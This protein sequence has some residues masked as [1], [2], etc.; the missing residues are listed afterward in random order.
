MN[1]SQREFLQRYA[2]LW[3]SFAATLA[4]LDRRKPVGA[5][6][7]A[8]YRQVCQHL[9]LAR[10]RGYS[11]QIV[12][13]LHHLVL[14]GHQHLYGTRR[15][16]RSAIVHF[17]AAGF[18]AAVRAEWRLVLIASALLVLPALAMGL[19]THLAPEMAYAMMDPA[20][21]REYEEMYRPD[22]AHFGREH[23]RDA[24]SD[25][26]MFGYYIWNNIQVAFQ[27][28]AT[29]IALG[30]G[31]IVFLVYNGLLMGA[32]AAHLQNA[33]YTQMFYSFVIGHGAFELTAIVFAG[34]A[35][36]RIG[37]ALL[38]PGRH[39]RAH[40]LRLAG[41]RT[42]PIVYG[43]AC[44]LVI[45][46]LLEAFWSSSTLIPTPAKFAM[47]TV[48]WAIVLTYFCTRGRTRSR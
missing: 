39:R 38:F 23:E 37:Q 7:P 21:A 9:A 48:Y 44:M 46:A 22:A 16:S 2:A 3:D 26:V 27:C 41:Q 12:E 11:P 15:N 35:G 29:G 17:L 20:Q 6:F 34:A 47:G 14:R 5:E 30:L 25:F 19:A 42:L 33:G 18:P 24:E 13:R 31:P 45:A 10:D 4:E 43:L 32:V 28:F 40:A 8:Q 36:L 1:S